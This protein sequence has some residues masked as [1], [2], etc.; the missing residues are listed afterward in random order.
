MTQENLKPKMFTLTEMLD[1][2]KRIPLENWTPWHEGGYRDDGYFAK[3]YATNLYNFFKLTIM[4]S[5]DYGE[6]NSTLKI[7]VYP[8]AEEDLKLGYFGLPSKRDRLLPEEIALNQFYEDLVM[9]NP[10]EKVGDYVELRKRLLNER[11]S[12]EIRRWSGLLRRLREAETL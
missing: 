10:R 6:R 9:A 7:E 11:K 8:W 5:H 12:R 3:G 2:A 1:L 4:R